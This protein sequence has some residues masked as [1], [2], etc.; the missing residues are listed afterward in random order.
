MPPIRTVTPFISISTAPPFF[1]VSV[2]MIASS[3]ASCPS[4][5]SLKAAKS[6]SIPCSTAARGSGTPI[7]PVEATATCSAGTA[8][9]LSETVSRSAVRAAMRRAA[10]SPASPVQAL[11]FPELAIIARS[12][13]A[14]ACSLLTMTLAACTRFVVNT[15][16]AAHGLSDTISARS[17]LFE[18]ALIP[19]RM[20]PALKPLGAHTPPEISFIE[21][22]LKFIHK[23]G[24]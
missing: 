21:P 14:A 4:A 11:A 6:L 16:A 10:R 8:P 3:A 13:P 15:P 17:R 19:H 5:S 18:D 23:K 22:P 9:P 24:D 1:R 12:V 2:V 20:P 7:T